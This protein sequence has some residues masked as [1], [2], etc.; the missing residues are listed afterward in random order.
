MRV[1]LLMLLV[2]ILGCGGD[3]NV[4]DE[5]PAHAAD[6]NP[7]AALKKLGA[8]GLENDD[9]LVSASEVSWVNFEGTQITDAGLVHLKSLAELQSLGLQ[10]TQVTEAGVADLQK[11]LPNCQ[12]Y[13]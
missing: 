7:V 3:D 11:A 5:P 9:G 13:K 1:L 4:A 8:D 2:G 12:I 6:A 10:E